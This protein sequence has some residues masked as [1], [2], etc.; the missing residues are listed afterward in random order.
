[1]VWPSNSWVR[2]MKICTRQHL[3]MVRKVGHLPGIRD[4]TNHMTGIARVH[5][6]WRPYRSGSRGRVITSAG[7]VLA[8]TFAV[9]ATFAGGGVRRDRVRWRWGSCWTR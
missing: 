7:L 8:G 5:Q 2:P 9:L 4:M 1:M 6:G 3:M